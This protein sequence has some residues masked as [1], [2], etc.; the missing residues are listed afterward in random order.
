MASADHPSARWLTRLRRGGQPVYLAVVQALEAAIRTGELQAGDQLPPQRAVAEMLGVDLTTVTRAYAAA[1]ARGLIEGAVGRGTFVRRGATDDEAGLIDLSMNLPPPPDGLSL[2]TLLKDTVRAILERTDPSALMA[3]HPGGGSLG[4]KTAAAAWL[5]PCLGDIAPERLLISP[6]AQTGL[7]AVLSALHA[8]GGETLVV[9]PLVYPGLLSGARQFGFKLAVCANDERGMDPQALARLCA[10]ERPTAI[11]LI[12]ATQNPT[13]VTVDLAR[14]REIV[15]VARRADAWIIEDDPYSRLFDAPVP[16]L[17]T[18]APERTFYLA[19]LSKCLSPGL[20]IAFLAPPEGPM[21]ERAGES[22]RAIAQMPSPLMGAVAT[23]WIRE[24]VA[25]RLLAGVR[26]EARA[27]RVIAA[28]VLPQ[29]RGA[30]EGI[31]VWLD[32]PPGWDPGRVHRVAQE[33]GLSLVTADTF[34]A[35][36]VHPSGLRISLGGP[37]SRPVL[38]GA[39][40]SVAALLS[41]AASPTRVI[42]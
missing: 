39:L 18:L 32:L 28:E 17:A 24:G 27:R 14:R 25:D 12:P 19:T 16:A 30:A 21:A 26:R 31:H 2:G 7:A 5:A 4:Q 8:A 41:G 10:G 34:A 36:Q 42:V 22:L 1:R 11:Y 15:E 33:K 35:S 23:S 40:E 9:E 6:G 29:A 20:R 13:A 37:A 3:Y 38:R